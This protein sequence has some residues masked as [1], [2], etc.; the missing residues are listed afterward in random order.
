[1]VLRHLRVRQHTAPA[2]RASA[3]SGYD[4]NIR[5]AD[6]GPAV[7]S[8]RRTDVATMRAFL[9]YCR[10]SL[11]RRTVNARVIAAQ[12][13]C[14][15]LPLGPCTA[16]AGRRSLCLKDTFAARARPRVL[17][18][19]PPAQFESLPRLID[20]HK[21]SFTIHWRVV[22]CALNRKRSRDA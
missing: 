22:S 13:C 1:M 2:P 9:M 21:L 8:A 18:S 16:L 3:S 14:S 11:V 5:Y 15:A 12:H 10:A 19:Q 7:L 6:R 4:A 17:C 20:G